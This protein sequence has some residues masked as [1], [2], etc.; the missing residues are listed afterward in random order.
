MS[1]PRNPEI[2]RA[3]GQAVRRSG[4]LGPDHPSTVE[5]KRDLTAA[6]LAEHIRRVVDA[7][8]PLSPEQREHLAVL[9]RGTRDA[10]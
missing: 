1:K 2:A 4:Y 5:A 10:T 7:A 9:L 3:R 8:P 6:V